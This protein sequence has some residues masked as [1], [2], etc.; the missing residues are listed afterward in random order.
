MC[1]NAQKVFISTGNKIHKKSR[2]FFKTVA[3]NVFIAKCNEKNCLK[4][5]FLE[6]SASPK[7]GNPP[8]PR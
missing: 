3:K 6:M 8:P 5:I 2:T 1:I 7:N 4:R